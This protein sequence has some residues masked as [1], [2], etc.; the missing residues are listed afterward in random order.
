MIEWSSLGVSAMVHLLTCAVWGGVFMYY[1]NS[2]VWEA[3]KQV[4]CVR[5]S[6]G[7]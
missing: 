1:G 4:Y 5:S 7:I 6:N 3:S 2:Y